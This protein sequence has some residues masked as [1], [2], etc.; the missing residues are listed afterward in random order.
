MK[1]KIQISLLILGIMVAFYC[2]YFTVTD[3][4]KMGERSFMSELNIEKIDLLQF[5]IEESSELLSSPRS[6][7]TTSPTGITFLQDI[8]Q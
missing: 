6:F 8:G 7:I 3:A 2:I 5:S 4:S 1:S